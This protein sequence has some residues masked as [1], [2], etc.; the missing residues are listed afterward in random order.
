MIRRLI[1][2]LFA[3]LLLTRNAY[4]EENYT[5]DYNSRCQQAYQAYVSMRVS[6]GDALVRREFLAN[7][8]NLMATYLADYGDFITLLF[9]G[10]S[11]DLKQRQAHMD[12]R[13]SLL[14]RAPD[15]TPWKKFCKAGIYLHWAIIRGWYGDQFKAATTF[16]KS[17]LLIKENTDRFPAFEQ[18]NI[19]LGMEEAVAGTI[20]DE[21]K[22]L[23][24]IFGMKGNVRKGAARLAKFI[25]NNPGNEPLSSEAVIYY[26][27]IRFY[28]LS[29]QDAVWNFVNSDRFTTR[30]NLL[31]CF[32][33][34]NIALN[35]H[36]ADV[37]L[38][39]LH[40]AAGLTGYSS[41]PAFDYET[42]N[43]LFLK[44]DA[45]CIT[46]FNRFLSATRNPAFRKDALMK[47]ALIYYLKGN[48]A[49]AQEIRRLIAQQGS[50][51][52]DADKQAQRFSKEGNWPN[53]AL[54]QARLLTEG[55]YY[56][57]ALTRLLA[58]NAASLA[59]TSDALEYAYRLGKAYDETGDAGNAVQYYQ[60]TIN[61]GKGQK[62][63]FAA[64][65]ALQMGLLYEK[66][67]Q[68]NEAL[69]YFRLC[70]SMKHHDFQS[71]IDQQAKAGVN[72]LTNGGQ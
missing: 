36:K 43:A 26:Q 45:A 49:Q 68:T 41:Y 20:P 48:Q 51:N 11:A 40:E 60:R 54:L 66:R 58:I 35:Y 72:R 16:R 53:A 52:T 14:D 17:Y 13:L 67:R 2:C 19:F 9:N 10:N 4:A 27:Y 32:V 39:T 29:Q 6:E 50:T 44:L 61:T 23:A 57:T 15:T 18:N 55:G 31:H 22:W 37:A 33:K 64:R 47:C 59:N 1:F 8:H 63:Q 34:A 71:S 69:Q 7:P 62:D 5:F 25:E 21:Y 28:L 46:Y 3:A 65:A 42:G 70:L 30:N 56:T 24:S 12:D 38:Q